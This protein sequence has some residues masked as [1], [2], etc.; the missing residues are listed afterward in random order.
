LKTEVEKPV[1]HAKALK[2]HAARVHGEI[3]EA[4][5]EHKALA[6]CG[7]GLFVVSRTTKRSAFSRQPAHVIGQQAAFFRSLLVIWLRDA[8]TT[9]ADLA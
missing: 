8:C 1:P 2:E 4:E 9:W 5:I 7:K 6:G 3:K